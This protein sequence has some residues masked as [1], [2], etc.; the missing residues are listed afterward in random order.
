VLVSD[1]SQPLV[2]LFVGC[3]LMC[4][5]YFAVVW[6]V[7]RDRDFGLVKDLRLVSRGR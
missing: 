3:V 7:F 4:C 2:R 1:L 5:G 6:F